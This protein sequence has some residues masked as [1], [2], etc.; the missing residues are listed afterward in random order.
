[1]HITETNEKRDHKF[2]RTR[3]GIWKGLKTG[4]GKG[5]YCNYNLK[6]NNKNLD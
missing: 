2:Q 5:K 6:N 3:K 4:K 1:M